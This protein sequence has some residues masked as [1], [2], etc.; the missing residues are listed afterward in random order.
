M[1]NDK[2]SEIVQVRMTLEDSNML[3]QSAKIFGCNRSEYIRRTMAAGDRV[4][5]RDLM[6]HL[7]DGKYGQ[8]CEITTDTG[9]TYHISNAVYKTRNHVV[10]FDTEYCMVGRPHV[11]GD[12]PLL[13]EIFDVATRDGNFDGAAYRALFQKLGLDPDNGRPAFNDADIDALKALEWR[14]DW[15]GDDGRD[16]HKLNELANEISELLR[17]DQTPN[18]EAYYKCQAALEAWPF[19]TDSAPFQRAFDRIDQTRLTSV[20]Q[21]AVEIEVLPSWASPWQ[22]S[23][24]EPRIDVHMWNQVF[25]HD[26]QGFP[27]SW[28]TE[29]NGIAVEPD[30]LDAG[31]PNWDY[32]SSWYKVCNLGRKLVRDRLE[33]QGVVFLSKEEAAAYVL[34][35]EAIYW[36]WMHRGNGAWNNPAYA[37]YNPRPP[38]W[39]ERLQWRI[40]APDTPIYDQVGRPAVG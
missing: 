28:P 19:P 5:M 26:S 22:H 33:Q 13:D 36:R 7:V 18:F 15:P 4:L 12:H 8:V 3:S 20:H 34:S 38:I 29:F 24:I 25:G 9:H 32:A 2:K 11:D 6:G 16:N 23:L 1:E 17:I 31:E 39:K 37:Q 35:D 40:K 30:M 21:V 14:R 10:V 27:Q